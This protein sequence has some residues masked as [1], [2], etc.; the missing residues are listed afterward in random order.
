MPGDSAKL[1]SLMLGLYEE[2]TRVAWYA[3]L[4]MQES[5]AAWGNYRCGPAD[6][7]SRRVHPAMLSS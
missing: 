6:R 4:S 5:F 7:S 3:N 1:S 2:P